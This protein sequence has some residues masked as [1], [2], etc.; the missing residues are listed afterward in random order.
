MKT[1]L[2]HCWFLSEDPAEMRVMKPYPPLGL[3]SISAWLE[4]EGLEHEVYD[5][6]FSTM[7]ELIGHIAESRPGLLGIYSTLMTKLNVIRVMH[8]IRSDSRTAAIR[9]IIGGPDARAHAEGYLAEGAD[10]VVP[11]EGEETLTELI[12][13]HSA[14]STALMNSIRGIVF[15]DPKGNIVR[16]AERKLIDPAVLPCPARYRVDIQRYLKV[17]NDRHGY[18][19]V[20]V[21]T[22]RGCPYTCNWCSKQIFGNTYRR[23]D[24][25]IVADEIA[26]VMNTFHPDRIW[27]TDDV[28]TIRKD[29]LEKLV[30]ELALRKLTISYECISREDCIDTEVISLLRRSGCRMIWIGAESGSQRILD[31]MN[32]RTDISRTTEIIRQARAAGIAAGTFL[33]LGYPGE[34]KKD[35]FLTAEYLK[36]A[37]PDEVTVTMAYPIEGTRFFEEAEK[38]FIRPFEWKSESERQIA[39]KKPYSGLFYRFAT[40]YLFNTALAAA[41]PPGTAR[42]LPWFKAMASRAVLMAFTENTEP[43]R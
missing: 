35:I 12:R 2:T 40:R 18:T 20:A 32:R 11:G 31:L 42:L 38:N 8:S 41:S 28:F 34:R 24:P 27:F 15:K 6:T 43:H 19:S 22:M 33:M 39:H 13:C 26:E 17:W 30:A 3:L 7:D 36:K 14:G 4:R 21:N 10:V 25:A 5:P 1:L 16:T 9:I 29:W 23:R 37:R